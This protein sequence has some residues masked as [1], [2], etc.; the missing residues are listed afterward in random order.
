[1]LIDVNVSRQIRS[2]QGDKEKNKMEK[3]WI[4]AFSSGTCDEPV[5]EHV[6]WTIS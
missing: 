4:L 6:Y 2:N 1:M 3:T 5:Y